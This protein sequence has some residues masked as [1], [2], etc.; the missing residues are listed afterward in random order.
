MSQGDRGKPGA[1]DGESVE[2]CRWFWEG[3][4]QRLDGLL[5]ALK[6]QHG[7]HLRSVPACRFP[8]LVANGERSLTMVLT[9]PASPRRVFD[10]WTDPAL[11]PRW[12]GSRDLPLISC[13]I[14]ARTGGVFVLA[15]RKRDGGELVLSG[16]Y[17]DV[18]PPHRIVH[19]GS[20]RGEAFNVTTSFAPRAAATEVTITV[21]YASRQRR[22]EVLMSQM[23]ER[24]ADDCR[25]LDALL[26]TSPD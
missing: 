20:M 4:L 10:A 19:T 12:L 18:L 11:V 2:H 13:R 22:D 1:A 3:S 17:I 24:I 14:D 15:W 7:R 5:Q 25:R 8:G 9:F 16:N 23:T 21:E 26:A 6:A